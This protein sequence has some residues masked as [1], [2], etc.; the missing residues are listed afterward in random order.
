MVHQ[1]LQGVT[2]K[3]I[4]Y[5]YP[6]FHSIKMRYCCVWL[7]KSP[8]IIPAEV[9]PVTEPRALAY[10]RGPAPE[11]EREWT[12]IKQSL[13]LVRWCAHPAP[14]CSNHLCLSTCWVAE[15][16]PWPFPLIP[17]S[18]WSCSSLFWDD[19]REDYPVSYSVPVWYISHYCP[20]PVDTTMPH[21]RPLWEQAYFWPFCIGET[22]SI[23][24]RLTSSFLI[25]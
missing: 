14:W 5:F 2:R 1:A 4:F 20:V 6:T 24:F 12:P 15:S 8:V 9:A 3:E 11:A 10:P 17:L 13:A 22:G 21:L 19:S 23:P 16:L 18:P 25:V 7:W